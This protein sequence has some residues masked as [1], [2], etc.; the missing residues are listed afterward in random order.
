[1]KQVGVVSMAI[2]VIVVFAFLIA[3]VILSGNLTIIP[4]PIY[5]SDSGCTYEDCH[6]TCVSNGQYFSEQY[7]NSRCPSHP[8]IPGMA[9]NTSKYYCVSVNYDA[10]ICKKK[11]TPSCLLVFNYFYMCSDSKFFTRSSFENHF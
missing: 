1:M 3:L 4:S 9:Y 10:E 5:F 7:S 8:T 11:V 6:D 2:L